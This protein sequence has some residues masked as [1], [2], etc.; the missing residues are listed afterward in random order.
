MG[1]TT[2]CEHVGTQQRE[3]LT[4]VGHVVPAEQN[5]EARVRTTVG[6]KGF[7][8]ESKM[9][10]VRTTTSSRGLVQTSKFASRYFDTYLVSAGYDELP[11]EGSTEVP[12][13]RADAQGEGRFAGNGRTYTPM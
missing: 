10:R 12:C 3:T 7:A 9:M 2:S 1:G 13:V 6:G 11:A 8:P 5:V 4:A